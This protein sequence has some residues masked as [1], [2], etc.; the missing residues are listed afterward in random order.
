MQL[1][2]GHGH[3]SDTKK[4]HKRLLSR[5]DAEAWLDIPKLIDGC[6]F[7]GKVW[8]IAGSRGPVYVSLVVCA[9]G[10]FSLR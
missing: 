9:T 2:G 1:L 4:M 5:D 6:K 10:P 7:T 8:C 3:V